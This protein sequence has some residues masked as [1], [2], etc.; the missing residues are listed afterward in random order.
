[1][2]ERRRG[3]VLRILRAI[4]RA[5]GSIFEEPKDDGKRG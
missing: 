2:G 5:L 1:M 3:W 4:V